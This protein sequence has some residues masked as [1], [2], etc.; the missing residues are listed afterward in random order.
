[1]LQFLRDS[2]I[3]FSISRAHTIYIRMY[4][5]LT[6]I[7]QSFDKNGGGKGVGGGGGRERER[8]EERRGRKKRRRNK[9]E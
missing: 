1:M 6:E 9:G 4:S 7:S 5:Y 2:P 3:H 8:E